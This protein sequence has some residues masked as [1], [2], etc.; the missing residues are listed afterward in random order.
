M[1]R[2]NGKLIRSS[3]SIL[4]HGHHII[5]Q[6]GNRRLYL[7]N[8]VQSAA[9]VQ[10]AEVVSKVTKLA[11][12]TVVPRVQQGISVG[13][14]GLRVYK[15]TQTESEALKIRQ[16]V[17]SVSPHTQNGVA[18]SAPCARL[19]RFQRLPAGDVPEFVQSVRNFEAT[20]TLE[21]PPRPHLEEMLLSMDE[22]HARWVHR[23]AAIKAA[24]SEKWQS[25]QQKFL[26]LLAYPQRVRETMFQELICFFSWSYKTALKHWGAVLSA[27]RSLDLPVSSAMVAQS[28]VLHILS[29]EED[30]R[31]PT[32]PARQE[33]VE[34]AASALSTLGAIA[35]RLAFMLG[36]RMGDV[37]NLWGPCTSEVHDVVSSRTFLAVRFRA[38]KTTAATQPY[39]LHLP[40]ELSLA[41][42]LR[43]LDLKAGGRYLFYADEAPSVGL[44]GRRETP[45]SKVALLTAIAEALRAVNPLLRCLSIR[46]GGLQMMALAGCSTE[47]LLSHSRHKN[48]ENLERYLNWGEVM[49][50]PARER[51]AVADKA[52]LEGYR[53]TEARGTLVVEVDEQ[54]KLR[55]LQAELAIASITLAGQT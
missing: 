13:T 30:P 3:S 20:A 21:P 27:A 50:G 18:A 28:S 4:Q 41:M 36:Q 40:A 1:N 44:S 9:L 34:A 7:Q 15:L 19:Q 35:L 12:S 31:R 33:E 26:F 17:Q 49:L 37:L 22:L 29:K 16:R 47:C 25:E 52:L 53:V 14:E 6:G 55:A 39:T 5:A 24:S 46:R 8:N 38:G 23:P 54:E 2:Q 32:T 43:A 48:K 45:S 10:S 51:W 42:E 11:R